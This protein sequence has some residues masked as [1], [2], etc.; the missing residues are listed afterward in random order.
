[1]R[2][3]TCREKICLTGAFKKKKLL[4]RFSFK[5]LIPACIYLLGFLSEQHQRWWLLSKLNWISV[6]SNVIPQQLFYKQNTAQIK[7]SWIHIPLVFVSLAIFK[8]LMPSWWGYLDFLIKNFSSLLLLP[9]SPGSFYLKR[10]WGKAL[11][12][13]WLLVS[14]NLLELPP[15]L[16]LDCQILFPLFPQKEKKKRKKGKKKEKN[17]YIP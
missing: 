12:A 2:K 15:A 3:A 7:S 11:E 1:M 16:G 10:N 8:S 4:W 5:Y 17:G 6:R 13:Q 9:C 14:P